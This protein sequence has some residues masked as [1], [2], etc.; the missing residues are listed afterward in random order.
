MVSICSHFYCSENAVLLRKVRCKNEEMNMKGK[1]SYGK[2]LIRYLLLQ[3][4]L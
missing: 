3:L 4:A 1:P 2:R